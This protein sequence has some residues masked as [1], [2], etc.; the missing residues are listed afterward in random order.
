MTVVALA[1]V[2]SAGATT[3]AL[4]LAAT[5]PSRRRVL[6]VECDPAGGD[7]APWCGLQT[8]P[9]LV[10]LA[11][12][13]RQSLDESQLQSHLQ[14]LPGPGGAGVLVGPA[15][16]EQATAA[17]H[18][19]LGSGLATVLARLGDTDVIVDCGRLYPG[20][21]A[22]ELASS[23]D[24]LLMLVRPRLSEVHHLQARVAAM[25]SSNMAAVMVGERPYGAAQ[26]SK[27][28]GVEV[29]AVLPE[30]PRAAEAFAGLSGAGALKRSALVRT[31]RELAGQLGGDATTQ[32]DTPAPLA[33]R[34]AA[35]T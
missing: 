26:V 1:S 19:L 18:T 11:A 31:A 4:A 8:E 20:S 27:A 17:L 25:R 24:A 5:W 3:T 13:A 16:A 33:E 9:G 32:P 6:V 35:W 28:L 22:L 34:S 2:K 10:T 23:A 21:P 12:S 7:V 14:D 30:D 15:A 29:V